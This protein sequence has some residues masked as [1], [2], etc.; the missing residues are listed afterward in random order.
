MPRHC[1]SYP[2]ENRIRSSVR[3]TDYG[4]M[5]NLGIS[6]STFTNISIKSLCCRKGKTH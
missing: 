4:Q 3:L 2:V 1:L 5:F 6:K